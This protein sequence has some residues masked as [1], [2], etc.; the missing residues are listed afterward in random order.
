MLPQVQAESSQSFP[1]TLT[2]S[3]SYT[4]G[5]PGFDLHQI[6]QHSVFPLFTHTKSH[7]PELSH[8]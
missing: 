3:K 5:F 8:Y 6:L 2:Y 1:G 4:L 7:I